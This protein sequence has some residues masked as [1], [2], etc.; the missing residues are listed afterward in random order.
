MNCTHTPQKLTKQLLDSKTSMGWFKRSVQPQTVVQIVNPLFGGNAEPPA[1]PPTGQH[2]QVQDHAGQLT[3]PDADAQ[4]A[5]GACDA[6]LHHLQAEVHTSA[7]LRSPAGLV[8]ALSPTAHAGN[9]THRADGADKASSAG[10][11]DRSSSSSGGMRSH[12]P[13]PLLLPADEPCASAGPPSSSNQGSTDECCCTPGTVGPGD[14]QETLHVPAGQS[15]PRAHAAAAAPARPVQGTHGVSTPKP[16]Y[17]LS[18]STP[19]AA[20]AAC[21]PM[22]PQQGWQQ[23]LRTTTEQQQP[24]SPSSSNRPMSAIQRHVQ[25]QLQQQQPRQQRDAAADAVADEDDLLAD[26]CA[27]LDSLQVAAQLARTDSGMKAD[28]LPAAIAA[29][30]A[31]TDSRR[32]S[33]TS[34]PTSATGAA[35]NSTQ[36]R[37]SRDSRSSNGGSAMVASQRV[38]NGSSAGTGAAA[39]RSSDDSATGGRQLAR[40][41][42][43]LQATTSNACMY[44]ETCDDDFEDDDSYSYIAGDS[45][46]SLRHSGS[47]GS[48]PVSF[49]KTGNG[50]VLL[51]VGPDGKAVPLT[52]SSA[53]SLAGTS[54]AG[55]ASG[56]S[57]TGSSS[58]GRPSSGSSS[59]G[60]GGGG[61]NSSSR[62]SS[63]HKG[64]RSR[65]SLTSEASIQSA[66]QKA[67]ESQQEQQER[68]Q[69]VQLLQQEQQRV[70]ERRQQK[71]EQVVASYSCLSP[72]SPSRASWQSVDSSR[73]SSG[74]TSTAA[75]ATAAAAPNRLEDAW[76]AIQAGAVQPPTSSLRPASAASMPA[77]VIVGTTGSVILSKSGSSMT[78]Q[79]SGPRAA[80][81]VAGRLQAPLP[82]S[83]RSLS[84]GA[85]PSPRAKSVAF[86]A[87]NLA[88]IAAVKKEEV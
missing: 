10:S 23:Q 15:K 73:P 11:R 43:R 39:G 72:H 86:A 24:Q 13:A 27:C 21:A 17:R 51:K 6:Q 52:E 29:V 31:S 74:Q 61:S 47:G 30:R 67:R 55:R 68:Q 66:A 70:Q 64:A 44:E 37:T 65:S 35:S 26:M 56:D 81:S 50:L 41:R 25:L 22:Q 80:A 49:G 78:T 8:H 28:K 85:A 12:A 36:A 71:Q 32:S 20:A 79:Q 62:E 77:G 16:A 53:R 2:Q 63:V 9:S 76:A 84:A 1:Q 38:S 48:G 69:R 58:N 14:L 42:S 88:A 7:Q 34:R 75:A 19:S 18:C 33:A 4:P 5:D 46:S 82:P 87:A 83:S 59:Y 45:P 54:S 40:G 60:A 57:G 3:S